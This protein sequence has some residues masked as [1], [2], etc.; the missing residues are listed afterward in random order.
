MQ[1]PSIKV[2]GAYPVAVTD[3]LLRE[4]I[5]T[6]YAGIRLSDAQRQSAVA[7][8]LEELSSIVLLEF[9]VSNADQQFKIG[10]FGQPDSDQAAY[11]EAYLTDDG[12]A[13]ISRFDQPQ[14]ATFRVTFFLHFFDPSKPLLSSYGRLQIPEVREMPKRLRKL[15]PYEPVD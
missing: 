15:L 1:Q 6:K 13:I 8:V 9:L 3:E 5:E 11:D 14:A 12:T 10:D 2:L 4:A 7:S